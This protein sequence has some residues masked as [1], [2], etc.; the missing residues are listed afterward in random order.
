MAKL[1]LCAVALIS[2]SIFSSVVC[3]DTIQDTAAKGAVKRCGGDWPPH[4]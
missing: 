4:D 3:V 2:M 1:M